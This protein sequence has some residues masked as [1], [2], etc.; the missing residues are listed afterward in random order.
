M[1]LN[2]STQND[3]RV[4]YRL[5]IRAPLDNP[6]CVLFEYLMTQGTAIYSHKEMASLA[7][8]AYWMPI[9]YEH[10]RHQL[11]IP[12][13]DAKLRQ[14]ARN[15][16]AHLRERAEMFNHHFCVDLYQ[17]PILPFQREDR[18]YF[19]S[20]QAEIASPLFIEEGWLLDG[21]NIVIG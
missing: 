11:N 1:I 10:Y 15:A 3:Y 2:T 19:L 8:R 21:D 5:R 4:D 12:F 17:K 14:M 18:S 6:D 9:A 13:S 20:Q 7:L 16:I